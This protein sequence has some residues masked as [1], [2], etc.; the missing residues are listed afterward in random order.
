MAE[1][2]IQLEAGRRQSTSARPEAGVLVRIADVQIPSAPALIGAAGIVVFGVLLWATRSFQPNADDW[3]FTYPQPLTPGGYF[4]PHNGVHWSTIPY[5]VYG[6][7]LNTFSLRTHVSL[8]VVTIVQHLAVVFLLFR[9]V[10]RRSGDLLAL[11]AASLLLVLGWGAQD[12]VGC[13]AGH[14][15]ASVA[16]GLLAMDLLDSRHSF[17]WRVPAAALALLL[18]VASSGYGLAFVAAAGVQIL[19][20]PNPKARLAAVVTPA[21]AFL[22]WY[23][24]VGHRGT[25]IAEPGVIPVNVLQLP[26]AGPWLVI[27]FVAYGLGAAGLAAAGVL[28]DPTTSGWLV[29][30]ALAVVLALVIAGCVRGIDS[31]VLGAFAGIVVL[32][33]TAGLVRVQIFGVNGAGD[34]RFMYPAVVF[35]ALAS[36]A[37][38]ARIRWRPLIGSAI[39]VAVIVAI[40]GNVAAFRTVVDRSDTQSARESVIVQTINTIR[41]SPDL[42]RQAYFW[43]SL[44][45]VG[46]LL[47]SEHRYGSP[48]RLPA[49]AALRSGDPTL[50]DSV[51]RVAVAPGLRL[52][53]APSGTVCKRPRGAD[54]TLLSGGSRSIVIL[55]G[56]AVQVA[57]GWAGPPEHV[58]TFNV[59]PGLWTLR[60]P[61]V[62]VPG[63]QWHVLLTSSKSLVF[64][65]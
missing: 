32:F 48:V 31:R 56:G 10:R 16:F 63:F 57:L 43:P 5:L 59:G 30:L 19:L 18:S 28:G 3:L 8:E 40:A 42:D 53:Q 46:N 25:S 39:G 4:I 2:A 64:R 34:S 29:Y 26:V 49:L 14:D 45:V 47:N 65:C 61:D 23:G 1:T 55:G 62:G 24:V 21:V 9:V 44:I 37:V 36:T 50:V 20:E 35:L 52:S 6:V 33:V 12:V 17:T 38:L 7:L 13:C 11:A 27:R 15:G 60:A 54:F 41:R 58:R 51:L 22:T